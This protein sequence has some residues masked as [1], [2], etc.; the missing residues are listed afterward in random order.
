[1]SNDE[2]FGP[3]RALL[4]EI[5]DELQVQAHLG[6]VELRDRLKDFERRW[7]RLEGNFKAATETARQD[8]DEVRAAAE[9][10][11]DEIR[12]GFEHLRARL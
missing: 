6:Q 10:L 4:R 3:E 2:I 9:K 8:A 7:H 1:M 12:E 5:R 11:G